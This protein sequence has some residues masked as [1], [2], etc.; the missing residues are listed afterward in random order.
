M[1]YKLTSEED[2]FYKYSPDQPRGEGG[3]FGSGR[4]KIGYHG[5]LTSNVD[6]IR[7]HGIRSG[8]GTVTYLSSTAEGALMWAR[9]LH[10]NKPVSVIS[11]RHDRD[12]SG[13]VVQIH[14]NIRADEIV[15]ITHHKVSE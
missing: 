8:D 4:H 15:D 12:V 14:R 1:R 9:V 2:P 7:K 13:E 5:T 3:R 11:V 10:G 6:N